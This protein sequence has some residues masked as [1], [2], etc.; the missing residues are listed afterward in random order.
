MLRCSLYYTAL[1]VRRRPKSIYYQCF[2]GV[3]RVIACDF[4]RFVQ[5]FWV[6]FFSSS[7]Y[8]YKARVLCC[9]TY[10]CMYVV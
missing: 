2:W 9:V 4:S 7:T 3:F 8:I 6:V 1:R 10:I 5:F